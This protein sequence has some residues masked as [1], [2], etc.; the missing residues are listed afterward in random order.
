[1]ARE[2]VLTHPTPEGYCSCLG[3][4]FCRVHFGLGHLHHWRL[5]RSTYSYTYVARAHAA[6]RGQRARACRW[7]WQRLLTTDLG[8]VPQNPSLEFSS[9]GFGY[10][11]TA[12]TRTYEAT[13]L[14]V[15]GCVACSG[16]LG[17]CTYA[18]EC[19]VHVER[20]A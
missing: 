6:R 3:F 18:C 20:D 17:G 2:A 11:L 12:T 5:R 13:G 8:R 10:D 7:H 1:M 4:T 16:G 19:T 9:R 15:E 14:T